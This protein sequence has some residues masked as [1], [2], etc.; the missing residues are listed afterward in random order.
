[1]KSNKAFTLIELL[2]VVLIIGIL[3]A[4]AVPQYQK[5]VLKANLHK[6]V[7]LVESIYQ[8]QQSYFLTHGTFADDIDNLDLSVPKNESCIK[9]EGGGASYYLCDFG[10]VGIFDN[11]RNVQYQPQKPSDA[12]GEIAYLHTL[13][14]DNRDS[15]YPGFILQANKRY[16]FARPDNQPAQDIC[17]NMGGVFF[18]NMGEQWKVYALD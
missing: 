3:A 4:I 10:K 14:E 2:V 18:V 17:Q 5:A 12:R 1:M 8:A 6:G 16:C 9:Q 13:T 15:S 7:S 11:T